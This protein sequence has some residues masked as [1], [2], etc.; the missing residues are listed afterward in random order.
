MKKEITIYY[1]KCSDGT[2]DVVINID[3]QDEKN[4]GGLS[5]KGL[6][7]IFKEYPDAKI[8]KTKDEVESL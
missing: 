6:I 8:I 2:Y 7:Y 3:G 4:F 5:E 1:A